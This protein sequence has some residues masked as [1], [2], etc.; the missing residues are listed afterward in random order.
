MVLK[1]QLAVSLIAF[2]LLL[3]LACEKKKAQLP[4][5]MQAPTITED[6]P[7]QIPEE[8]VPAELPATQQETTAEE[9]APKKAPAKHKNTKKSAQATPP[10]NQSTPAVAT[11]RSPNIPAV[12][13]PPPAPDTAIAAEVTS[14]LNRQKQTTTELLDTTEKDLKGLSRSLSHEEETMLAQIKAYIT[15]S[16]DATKDG[17]FERAYNLAM[18]AHLLS[19]ALVK[20]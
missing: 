10:A 16:R 2:A 11:S 5:K 1:R 13:A 8:P 20:K 6:I 4:A 9:S 12:E 19:D 15:Q 7:E 3:G 18:K 17:D 14:Q